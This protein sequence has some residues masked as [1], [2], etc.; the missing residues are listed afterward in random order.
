MLYNKECSIKRERLFQK[1]LKHKTLFEKIT[2]KIIF[3][4]I[5]VNKNRFEHTLLYTHVYVIIN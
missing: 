5:Y 1:V 3:L 2:I 4:V